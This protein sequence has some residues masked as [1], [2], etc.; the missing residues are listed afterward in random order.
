MDVIWHRLE[1]VGFTRLHDTKDNIG[2]QVAS[3]LS[4]GLGG[5][6]ALGRNYVETTINMAAPGTQ[7]RS[8]DW[9]RPIFSI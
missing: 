7:C 6:G 8:G 4:T 9:F 2:P 3:K 5:A 1:Q